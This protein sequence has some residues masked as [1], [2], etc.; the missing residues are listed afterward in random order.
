MRLWGKETPTDEPQDEVP[1]EEVVEQVAEFEEVDQDRAQPDFEGVSDDDLNALY[2]DQG[3]SRYTTDDGTPCDLE[4]NPIPEQRPGFQSGL[5]VDAQDV[6]AP[7][8]DAVVPETPAAR[9]FRSPFSDGLLSEQEQEELDGMVDPRLQFLL[10]KRANA[11]ADRIMMARDQHRE[12][13]RDL[14]IP[15]EMY[16]TVSR[17]MAEV[18]HIVPNNLRGTKA[19]ANIALAAAMVQ[20]AGENGSVFDVLQKWGTSPANAKP[21]APAPAQPIQ[22]K[23]MAPSQRTTNARPAPEGVRTAK[24]PASIGGLSRDEIATLQRERNLMKNGR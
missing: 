17:R 4:G 11:L 8:A 5:R 15:E 21:S 3:L 6:S 16:S 9:P 18:E 12:M 20:E 13:T 1:S 7:V 19:G 22:R 23:P 14:G 10:D 24:G 2:D